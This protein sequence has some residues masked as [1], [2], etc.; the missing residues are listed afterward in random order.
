MYQLR[1]IYRRMTRKMKRILAASGSVV[2]RTVELSAKTRIFGQIKPSLTTFKAVHLAT[3]QRKQNNKSISKHG[4][5]D[6]R[7]R[8]K[9]G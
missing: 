7:G 6:S 3:P 2:M 4:G 1:L 9:R 5:Q 8:C